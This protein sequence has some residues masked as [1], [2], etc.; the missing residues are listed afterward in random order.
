MYSLPFIFRYRIELSAMM[1]VG[2]NSEI[3]VDDF[4]LS[5]HCFGLGPVPKNEVQGWTP[6]MTEL[7]YCRYFATKTCYEMPET[8]K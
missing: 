1:F 3:S 5:P 6:E 7:E 2:L 8:R 4:S